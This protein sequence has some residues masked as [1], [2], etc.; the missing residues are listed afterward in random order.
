M[1]CGPQDFIY[2]VVFVNFHGDHTSRGQFNEL[3]IKMRR[4]NVSKQ[5]LASLLGILI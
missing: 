3:M 5:C 1:L 4:H 2:S